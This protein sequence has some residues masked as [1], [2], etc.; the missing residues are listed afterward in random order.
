[1]FDAVAYISIYTYYKLSDYLQK[2]KL[3]SY[4][5]LKEH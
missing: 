5:G 2:L 3:T 1:M 4:R